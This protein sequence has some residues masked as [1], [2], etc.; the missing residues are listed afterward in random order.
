M[1]AAREMIFKITALIGKII[2]PVKIKIRTRTLSAIQPKA[3][4]SVCDIA[5]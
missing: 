3:Q 2:E 4:G 5:S 1:V